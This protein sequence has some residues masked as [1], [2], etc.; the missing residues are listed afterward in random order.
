MLELFASQ[1]VVK[2]SL[3]SSSQNIELIFLSQKFSG[4][5]LQSTTLQSLGLGGK[6]ARFQLRILNL[7]MVLGSDSNNDVITACIEEK[8]SNK[9]NN[10][11]NSSATQISD[12]TKNEII[13]D[14]SSN[15]HNAVNRL[16]FRN[17][18]TGDNPMSTN[19]QPFIK[20][21]SSNDASVK[22][23]V[24]DTSIIKDNVTAELN[25]SSTDCLQ[26]YMLDR[27]KITNSINEIL[28]KNFDDMSRNVLITVLK[29]IDNLLSVPFNPKYTVINTFNNV[30]Q[31][32]I[33]KGNAIELLLAFGFIYKEEGCNISSSGQYLVF[34]AWV[35]VSSATEILKDSQ[36]EHIKSYFITRDVIIS[37]RNLV[38]STLRN[39]LNLEEDKLPI[40][41]EIKILSA[42]PQ[43][44]FDPF[45]PIFLSTRKEDKNV[46]MLLFSILI[47][48][49]DSY[50]II[51]RR[52]IISS[53]KCCWID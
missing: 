30:F 41:K 50:F 13:V 31:N 3:L 21:M 42:A 49:L 17:G 36:F 51:E 11:V 4:E 20:K 16:D 53:R 24:S 46:I 37:Y 14:N 26:E 12:I 19:E 5:Q 2:P 25:N 52:C 22:H 35:V 48:C 6:S 1:Q 28:S 40:L 7:S 23:Q 15:N 9:N 10:N 45:K 44:N 8:N 29:Y 43:V 27:N 32:I 18:T 33:V 34:P 38:I 47:C 39:E